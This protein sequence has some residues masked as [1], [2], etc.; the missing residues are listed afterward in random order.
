MSSSAVYASSSSSSSSSVAGT[1]F[2]V[3]VVVVVM[4]KMLPRLVQRCVCC[5]GVNA[6][7]L[8]LTQRSRYA[9]RYE[10]GLVFDETTLRVIDAYQE[11]CAGLRR[12]PVDAVYTRAF[13]VGVVHDAVHARSLKT[14]HG[15]HGGGD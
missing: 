7:P 4:M 12:A 8:Q 9:Q 3:V 15:G 13:G 1:A 11:V 10:G 6:D 2:V 14:A 5:Q